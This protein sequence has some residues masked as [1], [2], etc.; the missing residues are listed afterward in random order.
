[1]LEKMLSPRGFKLYLTIFLTG[2]AYL[3]YER[4]TDSGLVAALDGWQSDRSS[5]GSFYPAVSVV[6]PAV[7]LVLA[8]FGAGMTHDYK[9]KMGKFLSEEQRKAQPHLAPRG[10][11]TRHR[12]ATHVPREVFW[13]RVRYT[14]ISIV[15]PIVLGVGS[16][17][18][19]MA[20]FPRGAHAEEVLIVA[21][22]AIILGIIVR[23]YFGVAFAASKGRARPWGILAF[24]GVFGWIILWQ[25]DDY[26]L[27]LEE[28]PREHF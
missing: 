18:A 6:I 10:E 20:I 1:M 9:F 26:S 2:F 25:L 27:S 13:K 16:L 5:D 21:V 4:V 12:I 17:L 8:A 7:A 11:Q 23:I 28:D 19:A 22:A 3:M 14:A 24:D 15:A